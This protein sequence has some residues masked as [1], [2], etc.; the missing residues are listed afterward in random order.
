VY[1][2][3]NTKAVGSCTVLATVYQKYGYKP[4]SVNL[5]KSPGYAAESTFLFPKLPYCLTASKAHYEVLRDL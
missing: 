1:K 3:S 4:P 2:G 5:D